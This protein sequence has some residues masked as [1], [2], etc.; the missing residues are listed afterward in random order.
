MKMNESELLEML[1][2]MLKSEVRILRM[3]KGRVINSKKVLVEEKTDVFE[4]LLKEHEDKVIEEKVV[5]EEKDNISVLTEAS[6]DK[7]ESKKAGVKK[8]QKEAKKQQKEAEIKA[9]KEQKEAEIKA[10][11]EQKEAEKEAKKEQKEAEK[12]AKKQQ[13]KAEAKVAAKAKREAK[14]AEKLLTS[15]VESNTSN[16]DEVAIESNVSNTDESTTEE[17]E[18]DECIKISYEGKDYIK[19][20]QTNVVYNMDEEVVGKFN[21]ETKKIVF[22]EEFK[23]EEYA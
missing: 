13:K 16:T 8:E 4:E 11:K 12:E 17:E 6:I 1:S 22:D 5:I 18:E 2:E 14:K 15:V 10:K 9:K 7:K 23:E 20:I 19:S 21:E 3:T